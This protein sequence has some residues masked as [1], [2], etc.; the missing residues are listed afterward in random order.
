[1]D[2]DTFRSVLGRFASG[3]TILTAC[4]ASGLD[5]GMT[6]S[7]FSSLSLDPPL[8]LFCVDHTASMHGL[9]TSDPPPSC[10]ISIL[11]S[12]QEA[13]SRR[14]ADETEQRFDGIAYSRGERGVVLLDDSLAHLECTI[15]QRIDAGDH[16]VFIARLDRAEP[17]HGRPLLYY[18]GGYA[19]LER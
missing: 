1:M 13:W 17:R 10:G 19:Q 8:V 7:A 12:N 5:H 9:L 16:T 11:S 6:V 14:F 4:D 2:S 15:T 3:V 18:R